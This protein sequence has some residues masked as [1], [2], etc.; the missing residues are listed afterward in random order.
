MARTASPPLPEAATAGQIANLLGVSE[1][2]ILGRTSD[3]RL[4]KTAN[5]SV[6][7][8]SIIRA[9]VDALADEQR[10]RGRGDTTPSQARENAAQ[11]ERL[12]PWFMA[13]KTPERVASVALSIGVPV[14]VAKALYKR[15]LVEMPQLANEVSIGMMNT[16]PHPELGPF[17]TI[18]HLP[19]PDWPTL[20]V[21]E[22]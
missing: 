14:D 19:E 2:M 20:L 8:R 12:G 6:D 9:G 18:T 10:W 17:E 22:I 1:R 4:P 15:L 13:Q 3:G 11:L 5:G 7:L 21:D 16:P